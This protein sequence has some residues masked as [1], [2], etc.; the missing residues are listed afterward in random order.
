MRTNLPQL[1]VVRIDSLGRPKAGA[2]V[3]ASVTMNGDP[4]PDGTFSFLTGPDGVAR[5]QL[6]V[7][8][9]PGPVSIV[10]E[11]VKCATTGFACVEYVTLASLSVPGIVAQ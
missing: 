9:I 3:N 2:Q 8:T 7:G 4:R 10:V 11:Y 5:M 6:Q 1:V